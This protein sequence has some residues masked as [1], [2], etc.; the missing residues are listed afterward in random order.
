MRYHY[1]A[2]TQKSSSVRYSVLC[3]FTGELNLILAKS[4]RLGVFIYNQ[5]TEE[6]STKIDIPINGTILFMCE[7]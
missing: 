7:I 6:L 2:S 5:E 1:I 3:N 4:N